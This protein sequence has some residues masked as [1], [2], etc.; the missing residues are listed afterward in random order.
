[1]WS[2]QFAARRHGDRAWSSR[3]KIQVIQNGIE[4]DRFPPGPSRNSATPVVACFARIV[5]IKGIEV[6][7]EAARLVLQKH[8]AEFF[9]LGRSRRR[10]TTGSVS[11]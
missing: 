3:E 10:T 8:E 5:A 7:I 1:V 2:A 6:L 4:V 9:V 11:S